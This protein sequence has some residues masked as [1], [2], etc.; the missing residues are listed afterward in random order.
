MNKLYGNKFIEKMVSSG[1]KSSIYAMSEIID[2]SIDAKASEIDIIFLEKQS[3]EGG[4]NSIKPSEVFFID[5]G[6]GM[7]HEQINGCLR[8]SEGAGTA[9]NRIGTFGV[10]LP[11]SS[12]YV[13]RRVDVFSK[14]PDTNVWNHVFLD[15]DDQAS[16]EEPGYDLS[17]KSNPSISHILTEKDNINTVIKWSKINNLGASQS[18]TIIDRFNTLAGRIYRHVLSDINISV[19]S[20]LDGN[21][22]FNYNERLIPYDPLFLTSSK[23]WMTEAIW[24]DANENTAIEDGVGE[25][26]EFTV[27]YHYKKLIEGCIPYETSKPIFQKYDDFYDREKKIR[28]NGK[29]HTYKIRAAFALKDVCFPGI[30]KAG[31]RTEVGKKLGKKMSGDRHYNSANI[32]FIRA[33]REIAFGNWGFYTKTDETNRF[34]S[35]EIEFDSDLDKLMGLDYQKQSIDFKWIDNQEMDI[36][37]SSDIKLDI[38]LQKQYLYNHISNNLVDCIKDM[39][40]FRKKYATEFKNKLKNAKAEFNGGP[41]DRLPGPE[42]AVI[43]AIPQGRQYTPNQKEELVNFLKE[44]YMHIPEELIIQQV[45]NYSR[46]L[47]KTIILYHEEPTGNLFEL[48]QKRGIDITFINT[49]HKY[50]TNIIEPL[51]SQSEL[52]VFTSAI[53][54]IICSYAYEMRNIIRDDEVH[55]LIL[56]RYINNVSSRLEEF[57]VNGMISVDTEFY[58]N[59]SKDD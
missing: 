22:E 38:N 13:G 21:T 45:E 37:S 51:K 15:L 26:E 40:G 54:M 2:N 48:K 58:Q 43:R 56:D 6:S 24:N 46:G 34:W 10:G 12:I 52:A 19:K 33:K 41:A 3:L 28:I 5:N 4:R 9:D 49:S 23:N 53:E 16:R 18:K 47:Y 32:F 57:I 39:R 44:N 20:I 50:Y 14:D 59:I 29:D 8:F 30:S 27:R 42:P 11:N 55:K 36:N 25:N 7:T 31:G 17:T 1:Y 35:I